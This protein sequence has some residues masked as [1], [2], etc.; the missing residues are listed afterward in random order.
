M[1][2]TT[3]TSIFAQ[4]IEL[5]NQILALPSLHPSPIVNKVFTELV[6]LCLQIRIPSNHLIEHLQ[7]ESHS[8]HKS[9]FDVKCLIERAMDAE[10]CMER[11]W[12]QILATNSDVVS[13]MRTFW[14][15]DNYAAL[16]RYE[17]NS[18]KAAGC[19][20]TRRMAFIGSGPLPLSAVLVGQKTQGEVVLYDKDPEANAMAAAWVQKLPAIGGKEAVAIFSFRDLDI[21]AEDQSVFAN[22]DVV[23]VAASVGIDGKEKR[24]IVEYLMKWMRPGTFLAVRSVEMGCSLL[25]PEVKRSELA[26]FDVVRHD[27]PPQGVVNSVI[28]LRV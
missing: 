5:Y 23:W 28:V 21:W 16:T 22:Y 6:S 9:N 17:L 7:D 11:Y 26:N 20:T 2:C 18:L 14:Y 8:T 27:V 3:Q 15:W 24:A 4:I 19:S 10:G 13:T 12:A 25:Y 1:T